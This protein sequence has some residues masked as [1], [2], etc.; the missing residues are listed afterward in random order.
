M[1]EATDIFFL[2]QK[3][4][5]NY[6]CVQTYCSVTT[7]H[8]AFDILIIFKKFLLVKNKLKISDLTKLECPHQSFKQNPV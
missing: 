5:F 3:L 6:Q 7:K 2:Y 8:D 4:K 1:N